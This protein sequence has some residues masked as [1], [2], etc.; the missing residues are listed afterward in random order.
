MIERL[1][2][3]QP[4]PPSRETRV[5]GAGESGLRAAFTLIELMLVVA[6]L[7]ITLTIGVPALMHARDHNS[8]TGGMNDILD[9][10]SRARAQAILRAAPT[11]IAIYPQEGRFQLNLI[12]TPVTDKAGSDGGIPDPDAKP[13]PA[14]DTGGLPSS[15]QISHNVA[16]DMIDV[17]FAEYKD[18][19]EAHVYFYP[20][21]TADRL[22]VVLHGDRN[23]YRKI[24]V[25]EVTGLAKATSDISE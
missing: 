16:I 13:V 5:P 4:A 18:A 9:V 21:G 22:T 14:P 24:T 25:D 2:F 20:N 19:E 11:E 8:L 12:G 7:G 1:Q 15:A 3:L 10:C 6:I 17:N 23:E